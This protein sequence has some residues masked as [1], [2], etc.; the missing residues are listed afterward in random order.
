MTTTTTRGRPTLPPPPDTLQATVSANGIT[1]EGGGRAKVRTQ[2]RDL[3]ALKTVK[4][5]IW[6]LRGVGY[7]VVEERRNKRGNVHTTVLHK[8]VVV[9]AMEA[10][11]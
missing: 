5:A 10:A 3:K 9:M 4:Q 6:A 7:V 2:W 11:A 1:I 8:R